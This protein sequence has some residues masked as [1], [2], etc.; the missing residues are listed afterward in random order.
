[1]INFNEEAFINWANN[2]IKGSKSQY[3][4]YQPCVNPK[5]AHLVRA[6]IDKGCITATSRKYPDGS[7]KDKNAKWKAWAIKC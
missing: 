7:G 2:G 3:A 5:V 4:D 6:L 1:M